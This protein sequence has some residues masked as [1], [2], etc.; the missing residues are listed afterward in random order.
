MACETSPPAAPLVQEALADQ[1]VDDGDQKQG[2]AERAL[3]QHRGQRV[4]EHL[5][6]Q[7]LATIGCDVGPRQVVERQLCRLLVLG[8]LRHHGVN[9]MRPGHGVARPIGAQD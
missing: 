6:P 7:P 8:E 1:L 4:G 9:R 5:R 3:M 2:M